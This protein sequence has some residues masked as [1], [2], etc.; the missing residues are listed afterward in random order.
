[1]TC[2]DTANFSAVNVDVDDNDFCDSFPIV[3]FAGA[4]T[5]FLKIVIPAK[6]DCK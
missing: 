6:L 3:I 5:T 4:V 2:Y 1:M